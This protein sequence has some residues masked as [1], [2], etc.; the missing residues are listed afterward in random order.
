MNW[1]VNVYINYTVVPPEPKVRA[2][3]IF[4]HSEG[5]MIIL[6]FATTGQ[7]HHITF[8]APGSCNVAVVFF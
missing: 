8:L 7:K 6:F 1:R 4:S 5:N 2:K 3:T